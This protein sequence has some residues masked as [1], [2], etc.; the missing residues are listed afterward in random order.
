MRALLGERTL[1]KQRCNR[2]PRQREIVDV[3]LIIS[4]YDDQW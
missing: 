1:C 3:G 2:T 4:R